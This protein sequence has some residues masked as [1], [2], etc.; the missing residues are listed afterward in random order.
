[1]ITTAWADATAATPPSAGL[2]SLLFLIV[3]AVLFYFIAIRPQ[4]KRIKEH[5]KMVDALAKGDEAVTNGG[6]LGKIIEI[7][8]NFVRLE[9]ATNVQIQVQKHMIANLMPKGTIKSQQSNSKGNRTLQQK[10]N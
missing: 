8:E 9:I 7:N 4:S 5:K 6:I 1:M 2:D 3:M 10:S